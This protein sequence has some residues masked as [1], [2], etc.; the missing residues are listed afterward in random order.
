MW[1]FNLLVLLS[2]VPRVDGRELWVQGWRAAPAGLTSTNSLSKSMETSQRVG[3]YLNCL[4]GQRKQIMGAVIKGVP[5]K[6]QSKINLFTPPKSKQGSP[7]Y[8]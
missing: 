6:P 4:R 7:R 1:K 5:K 2:L 3:H 8:P